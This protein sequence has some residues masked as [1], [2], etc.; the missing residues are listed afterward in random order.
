MRLIDGTYEILESRSTGDGRTLLRATD[1]DGV[2]VRIVWYD[3]PRETEATFET[4]RRALRRMAREGGTLLRDVVSRPGAR[5]AVWEDPAGRSAAPMDVSWQQRLTRHGIDP[6]AA[7]VRRSGSDVVLACLDWRDDAGGVFPSPMDEAPGRA[8]SR[9]PSV[10][11]LPPAARTWLTSLVLLLAASAVA[12]SGWL[13]ASNDREAI[14]PDVLGLPANEAAT[15]L[16]EAGFVV[17]ARSL[18]GEGASGT[19][20]TTDPP[21]G[22]ML[23]PGRTI[24]MEYLEPREGARTLVVPDVTGRDLATSIV[25]L[26]EANLEVGDVA[27][28]P[29]RLPVGTV[30]AQRPSEGSIVAPGEPVHVL[31]SA[32]PPA[33]RGFLPDLVGLPIEEARDVAR[34]AGITADRILVDAV[35]VPGVPTGQVVAMTPRP[36]F[37][38][39]IDD[40][41]VRL[42]VADPAGAAPYTGQ[43][44]GD[45]TDS[46]DAPADVEVGIDPP[47]PATRDGVPDVVGLSVNEAQEVLR[48][49]GLPTDLRYVASTD[50]PAGVVL[51]EPAPGEEAQ[52]VTVQLVVNAE[53]RPIPL[54]TATAVIAEERLRWVPYAF[55][56]DDVDSTSSAAVLATTVDGVIHEVFRG[57]VEPGGRLEGSWATLVP[58]PVTFQLRQAGVTVQRE[59]VTREVP[60]P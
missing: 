35:A 28:I 15:Q 1:P 32:G 57:P 31:T 4:Y 6:A 21:A 33:E 38:V 7:D 50:L 22:A 12:L 8:P 29:A 40:V 47:E 11:H 26:H 17:T 46:T 20:V 16:H 41:T 23:R 48:E 55:D 45:T 53:A 13:R 52:G 43:A 2:P 30:I 42:Q 56:L 44:L 60:G 58:G 51:Q 14:V 10:A 24:L 39:R 54:P 34:L 37:D 3:V 25:Q 36:W 27:E 19:V 18:A 5:Y 9:R 59:V 49:A